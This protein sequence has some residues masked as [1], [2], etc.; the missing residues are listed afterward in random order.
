MKKLQ[1]NWM[2]TKKKKKTRLTLYDYVNDSN[3]MFLPYKVIT[4]TTFDML[5]DKKIAIEIIDYQ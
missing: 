3:T 4:K 2:F 5:Q 1:S